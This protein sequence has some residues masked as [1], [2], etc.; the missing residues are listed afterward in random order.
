MRDGF[1]E[2]RPGR[3]WL[4]VDEAGRRVVHKRL[5]DDCCQREQL[6]PSVKLRLQR[7]RELPLASFANILGVERTDRGVVLV[8][9]YVEGVSLD[10]LPEA[11][12]IRMT[13]ELRLAVISMHQHGMVHGAIKPGN[14]IIAPDGALRLVDPSPLLHD[15]PA[16]DLAA[17]DAL[18]PLAK[19]EIDPAQTETVEHE[20]RRHRQRTLAAAVVLATLALAAAVVSAYYLRG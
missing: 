3:T 5:P 19:T 12:R 1:T 20:D 13:R 10:A 2:L 11:D 16:V 15:D 4:T 14:V 18:D 6:H 17:V 9:E 8:S 7:L